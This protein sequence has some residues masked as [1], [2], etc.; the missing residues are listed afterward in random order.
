MWSKDLQAWGEMGE[1][2]AGG[3]QCFAFLPSM[4]DIRAKTSPALCMYSMCCVRLP[5]P[6][7]QSCGPRSHAKC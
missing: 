5:W 4:R 6:L 2:V 3:L 7:W 1:R